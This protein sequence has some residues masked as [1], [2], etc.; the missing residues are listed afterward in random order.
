MRILKQDSEL[1]L[2]KGTAE[3]NPQ[4]KDIGMDGMLKINGII[5]NYINYSMQ[6]NYIPVIRRLLLYNNSQTA[7]SGLTLKITAS[8]EFL[9]EYTVSVDNIPA[10]GCVQLDTVQ[11][12][13]SAEYL[14][15]LTERIEG[16]L[17]I[18]VSDNEG[19]TL[20][21]IHYPI[22]VLA[23]DEWSGQ[24]LMPELLAAFI[25]PNHPEITGLVVRAGEI[26][27]KWGKDAQFTAYQSNNPNTV[28]L[29]MAAVYRAIQNENISYC[30]PP[31][32]FETVGQRV[33]LADSIIKQK[34]ATCLD[35][36]LL[37]AGC[38]EAIGLN[39][40]IVIME[41]HA[42]TACW[43]EDE[44]FPE[45][46]QDDASLLTKRIA[47]GI[48]EICAAECTML[49]D[50]GASFDDACKKAAALLAGDGFRLLIDVRR[51]RAGAIRPL[52]L[53]R[54][55]ENGKLIIEEYEAAVSV[56]DE[57]GSAPRELADYGKITEASKNEVS[58]KTMW[59]R[60][61][62]DLSLRN[63]LVSFRVTKSSLQ[64]LSP[65]LGALENALFS[66][67]DFRIVARSKDWD[68]QLR[69][70][71]FYSTENNETALQ[72]LAR[73]EFANK[74]LRCFVDETELNNTIKHLYRQAKVS[75]EE[76]GTNTLYLALGFLRWYESDVS[77]KARYAPLILLPVDIV[78]KS[79]QMGYVIR[80]RDEEPQMNITVLEML[81]QDFGINIGGLDPLPQDEA[82]TDIKLVFTAVRQAIKSK[83]RWDV[84]ELAFM[85]LFSFSQFIMWNDI[86]NRSKDLEN[87]KLVSSLIDGR[88][89][90]T[91]ESFRA[92]EDID[93]NIPP[94]GIALP[95]SCDSSQL[96]A[97][98]AAGEGKSFVLHGPPGTGKS[99]TITN[100]I[101]NALYK[102]QS[103]LFV[104]EKMAAL[105]VVQRRL[106]SIG[107]GPF[108][109]ELHSNKAKKKTVL[110]QLEKALETPKSACG[111][112]FNAYSRRISALKSELNSFSVAMHKTRGYGFS[113][114]DAMSRC[115]MCGSDTP[116][117][118]G[119]D[120]LTETLN[121]D[122]LLLWKDILREMAVADGECGGVSG[123]PL[124]E[125][126]NLEYTPNLRT[127][128][129]DILDKYAEL[130]GRQL[131]MID[132]I[133]TD[134]G[135]GRFEST[136]ALR[137]FTLICEI[138]MQTQGI[139]AKLFIHD[140]LASLAETIDT[141]C[142]KGEL[143][144]KQ[145]AEILEKFNES[146]LSVNVEAAIA[147]QREAMQSW[148][149]PKSI[150]QGKLLKSLTAHAKTPTAYKKADIDIILSM[151]QEYKKN[152]DAVKTCESTLSP[153]Y[154]GMWRQ[155]VPDWKKI[156]LNYE[157]AKTLRN[158]I[159]RLVPP[160]SSREY[161]A[162]F[163]NAI[164]TDPNGF[165]NCCG[166]SI[167]TFAEATSAML[168]LERRLTELS[169]IDFEALRADEKYL[170]RLMPL[171]CAWR[172]SLSGIRCW[173]LW[174]GIRKKAVQS[175]LDCA[176]CAL[177]AGDI[178]A[179]ELEKSFM[180]SLFKGCAEK[181]VSEEPALSQFSGMLFED[182]IVKFRELTEQ[183]HQLTR[184]ELVAR[185]SAK[186][187]NATQSAAASSE[188]GILQRAI[189]SGGR[190]LSIRRLFESTPQL[191]RR[192]SPC[193]LMSP[194]SVA[195]YIDP[196]FEQF[197]LVVFDEASQLP[198]SSAVGAIARGKN[199]I[200]VGDPKQLP[201]T[202]F[203][204]TNRFD[205]DNF[206]KE[207]LESILDDCL[208]LSMPSEHLLWHYRSRH[209]SLI[210]FSNMQF[211]EN[212]LYTFPSPNDLV[213]N[214]KLIQVEGCYDRGGTKQN[215]AEAEQ[216]VSEILRRLR[217]EK[218]RTRS[219]GVVTFSV[220]Q[221]NLIDD[222]LME[223]F[224]K[225][226][227]LEEFNSNS[228]EPLFIKNLENVQGDERDV[229]MFSIGYAPD[230]DGKLTL[231]FGPLNRDGGWRRL[232]VAVSRARMEMLVY[233]VLRP[234]QIDL[235]KTL[236][237][238]IAG[239][240][241]FLEFAQRGKSALPERQETA[242]K[243]ATFGGM[244]K[245][246]AAKIAALG[247]DVRTS[248]GASEYKI[249]IGIVNPDNPEEYLLGILLDGA[250]YAAAKTAQ[251]RNISQESVLRSLGWRI[252]RIWLLDWWDSPDKVM[253]KIS[254]AISDAKQNK[255]VAEEKP[256]KKV[257]PAAT[258][259]TA[260]VP[261]P[262]LAAAE[263]A[264]TNS[265]GE[266]YRVTVLEKQDGGMN[267]FCD[268]KSDKLI[269]SQINDIM[270]TEAPISRSLFRRRLLS[271][272]GIT[273]VTARLEARL[274]ELAAKSG[275]TTVGN[276]SA[277]FYWRSGVKPL[278]Y[279]GFR[280]P[281]NN[282][283]RRGIE[284]IPV[285][286]TANAV[287][288]I[289]NQQMGMSRSDLVKQVYRLYGFTR[290]SEY[291]E[292]AVSDAAA[293]LSERG[294]VKLDG[295]KVSL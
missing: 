273:R 185:L 172:D 78:R 188:I 128:L 264:E 170:S 251:D 50:S 33:R 5:S 177:E 51:A 250:A 198:T 295:D 230:K 221:Q 249:D 159:A 210:A 96:A 133:R 3:S 6:R 175:G 158:E 92:P 232:N 13:I 25:T 83:S 149:L 283:E 199:V 125:M 201:P 235:S 187:P 59:E 85:G 287:L 252:C 114:Y 32:S 244:E 138:L 90:W 178:S 142:M 84:E 20:E 18:E 200:V 103:V 39:P 31:A 289:L 220:V 17:V 27:R 276:G 151:L 46:L 123:H 124:K 60:K 73:E 288:Y 204:A 144:D 23:F 68:N 119:A 167:R 80:L 22:D 53:R 134:L 161:L 229:I 248:I 202:S 262:K 203:F 24:E 148:F 291:I 15:G 231:N 132:K 164:I 38:L 247:Y 271:A 143:R 8:P 122:N 11:P 223:A 131:S 35:L 176:V 228:D 121:T 137:S 179:A 255:P 224:A 93:V 212:K 284:D 237:Q 157:Q 197:D 219:I 16:E 95:I 280:T 245:Q 45:T 106:A 152:V 64:I 275:I 180:Y 285:Q 34:L 174:L 63:M 9:H 253:E 81:R 40:I 261:K 120:R 79:A 292:H 211:Y 65:D 116:I 130:V 110:D 153:L 14:L 277:I 76:N 269:L 89:K 206:E 19:S 181:T 173:S 272:W 117:V 257:A 109:L 100:I 193:M 66:G 91:E 208:A 41:G 136:E 263:T 236:A 195:Q 191:L 163:A 267:A 58:R 254:A 215:R 192:L 61:L 69:D 135:I 222:L 233:S 2:W 184:E 7:L 10:N 268:A 242:E 98:C 101:A 213:S 77:E 183:F 189:K 118:K 214:V 256:V 160:E 168:T 147:E 281:A 127:E 194:I 246:I 1:F 238:G 21:K 182:K 108:C 86:R 294:L 266:V 282:A 162:K 216:I 141:A 293:L 88:L 165:R 225:E 278:E 239:L 259:Q 105:S 99:Q 52:P 111:E 71:K 154:E 270:M 43:L 241:A 226:P 234:E 140:N 196:S 166:A 265:A 56:S 240:K 113:L 279:T 171:S 115:A 12:V 62:L 217:D 30:V 146:I 48:N 209:E 155:G 156:R 107:L 72:S 75:L 54:T 49:T 150:K 227:E 145:H 218:L 205:E 29:F 28:R 55:D 74:R 67:S 36:S 112:D 104:A 47:E 82:G 274:D 260:P 139:P 186:I 4:R 102:G 258:V 57:A 37:Y 42:F 290:T 26:L 44:C 97:V 207:D 129:Q 70:N 169:G 126:R 286:E 94:D 87:N 243:K 190:M